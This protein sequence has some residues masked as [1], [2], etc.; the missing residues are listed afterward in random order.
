MSSGNIKEEIK[1]EVLPTLDGH[2]KKEGSKVTKD[3]FKAILKACVINVRPR[4]VLHAPGYGL[5]ACIGVW[6][7]GVQVHI[8]WNYGLVGM[9]FIF[10]VVAR[11]G[12]WV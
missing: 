10:G 2:Y 9:I 4:P 11:A 5:S 1:K 8:H 12:S 3:E 7:G 6:G